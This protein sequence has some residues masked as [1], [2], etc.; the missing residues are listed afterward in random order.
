MY[1]LLFCVVCFCCCWC[2]LLH[3]RTCAKKKNQGRI[4]LTTP[5]WMTGWIKFKSGWIVQKLLSTWRPLRFEAKGLNKVLWCSHYRVLS[6]FAVM[7]NGLR[8]LLSGGFAC[9][10]DGKRNWE[11]YFNRSYGITTWMMLGDE[12]RLNVVT[13][14]FREKITAFWNNCKV[15]I[16]YTMDE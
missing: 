16:C 4:I 8:S 12:F 1:R 5:G 3:Q 6:N 13:M 14:V 2:L 9:A 10:K 7:W 11:F 15:S